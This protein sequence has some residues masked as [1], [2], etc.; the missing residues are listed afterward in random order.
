MS[1]VE[2]AAARAVETRAAALAAVLG[3]VPG[4][5]VERDG[6]ELVLSGRRLRARIVGER[7]LRDPGSVF[8]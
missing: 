8:R 5:S 4:V 6:G 7:V 2:R 3:A 1:A